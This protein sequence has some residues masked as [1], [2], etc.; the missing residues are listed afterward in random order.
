MGGL[1]TDIQLLFKLANE[2]GFGIGLYGNLNFIKNY[3]GVSVNI[4][5]GNGK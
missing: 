5:L 4:T 2:V 3:A 1:R